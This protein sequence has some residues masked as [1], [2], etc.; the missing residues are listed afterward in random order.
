[1]L[2]IKFIRLCILYLLLLRYVIAVASA[3]FRPQFPLPTNKITLYY[4]QL[5]AAK[6]FILKHLVTPYEAI[7]E[8]YLLDVEAFKQNPL[9][10]FVGLN[11]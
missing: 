8:K 10:K 6:T 1:M 9:N 7:I 4:L 2:Q 5:Q 3:M 11:K